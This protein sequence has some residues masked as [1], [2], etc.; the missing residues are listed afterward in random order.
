MNQFYRKFFISTKIFTFFFH[1]FKGLASHLNLLDILYYTNLVVPSSLLITMITSFFISL[2]FSLQI[3]KEFLYLDAVKLVG[4]VFSM[5][6]VRE[7]SPVLTS[8]V[9]IGKV[10]SSF[11]AEL[12]TIIITEQLDALFI[13]GI[14]PINYLIVPRIISMI[15]GLPMLNIL[16]LLTSFLA[17]SFVCFVLYDI[18]PSIFLKSVFYSNLY[19]D[20]F[21][22]L[23]KTFIFALSTSVISCVWGITSIG[24]SRGVGLSTTSSVV[25]CLISIFIL[26]F[27]L[28]YILFDN[29]ISSF[30]FL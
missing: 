16:S 21:K 15:L 13:L 28:S 9:I 5:S 4:A 23:L 22:S 2:V 12:A 10:C 26:N 24:G 3:V 20:L 19:I 6:F 1:C 17:G 11:T 18:H 7:L 30:Q 29:L 25:T 14:N 27:I 8:I